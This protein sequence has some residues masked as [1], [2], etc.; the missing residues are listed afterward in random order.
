M[1]KVLLLNVLIICFTS[2]VVA[3]SWE[4]R[5]GLSLQAFQKVFDNLTP[6]GYVPYEIDAINNNG[7]VLFSGVWRQEEGVVW[8]ARVNLTEKEY[9]NKFNE[10]TPKGY[11]P[12]SITVYKDDY[13]NTK[14]GAIW[15]KEPG[16]TFVAKHNL[17]E[18]EYKYQFKKLT[19]A[20]FIP[21]SMS[22][23]FEDN[24]IKFAAAWRKEPN[25]TFVTKK[26][27]SEAKYQRT[28]DKLT[29]KGF[30][31]IEIAAYQRN[32]KYNF[33]AV[34]IKQTGTTWEARHNM[35]SE[36]YQ[37][38]FDDLNSKGYSPYIISTYLN[39]G[40]VNYAVAWQYDRQIN[41]IP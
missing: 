4:A 6:K 1:T 24:V 25:V 19:K 13:N 3:Q 33:A 15:K 2:S 12:Y 18:K 7:Q 31:P 40:T 26:H 20:G 8:E 22:V 9:Q 5:H 41:R 29:S 14:Y 32:G 21:Y 11:V 30:V 16:I 27:L 34:W 17:T 28:F 36:S 35:T 10:L 39:E 37:N 38:T 23:Y